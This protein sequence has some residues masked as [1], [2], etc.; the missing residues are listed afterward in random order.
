MFSKLEKSPKTNTEF[1]QPLHN[2]GNDFTLYVNTSTPWPIFER[3]ISSRINQYVPWT[4]MCL[5]Y[6]E[7]GQDREG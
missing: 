2:Y 6:G 1:V 4:C 7:Q 5:T 3:E